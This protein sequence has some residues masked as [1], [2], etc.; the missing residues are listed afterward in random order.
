MRKTTLLCVLIS[1]CG[2]PKQAAHE[3][4]GNARASKAADA[5][6]R[7][8]RAGNYIAGSTRAERDEAYNDYQ[9]TSGH[10]GARKHRWFER[11]QQRHDASLD[12][13]RLD[14]TLVTNAEYSIPAAPKK[15][16]IISPLQKIP[17]KAPRS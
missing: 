11:E 8:I 6:M 17:M 7:L 15:Y 10:D 2:S 1:A 4:R 3:N 12:A 14:A 9:R 13:Y 16:I 5:A